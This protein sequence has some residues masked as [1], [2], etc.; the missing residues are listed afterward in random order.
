ME[1]FHDAFNHPHELVVHGGQ[2]HALCH[3][4][5]NGRRNVAE[6]NR[7][8][9]R[10]APR[11]AFWREGSSSGRPHQVINVGKR[12]VTLVLPRLPGSEGDAELV[13][14][15][16]VVEADGGERLDDHVSQC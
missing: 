12:E 1:G 9:Y 13:P 3:K 2:D 14:K 15:P 11:A 7:K 4:V 5:A 6:T 8:R 16:L 10:G